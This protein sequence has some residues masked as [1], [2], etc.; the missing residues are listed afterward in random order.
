MGIYDPKNIANQLL[1]S[2]QKRQIDYS[3]VEMR[4]TGC[5]PDCKM[6]VYNVIAVNKQRSGTTLPVPVILDYRDFCPLSVVLGKC[7]LCGVG[8][9]CVLSGNVFLKKEG[10]IGVECRAEFRS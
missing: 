8:G 7:T 5:K 2:T 6:V 4:Q 9:R 10:L 3:N 1:N